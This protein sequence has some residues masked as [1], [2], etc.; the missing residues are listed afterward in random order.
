MGSKNTIEKPVHHLRS[1]IN[2]LQKLKDNYGINRKNSKR[3]LEQYYRKS[4]I[5]RRK[6]SNLSSLEIVKKINSP[7]C[8]TCD[9]KIL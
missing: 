8:F 2:I 6:F 5:K 7:K 3:L 9:N 4:M 1:P